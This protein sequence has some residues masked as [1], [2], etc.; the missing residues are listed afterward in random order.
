MEFKSL[1][2]FYNKVEKKIKTNILHKKDIYRPFKNDIDQNNWDARLSNNNYKDYIKERSSNG[3]LTTNCGYLDVNKFINE[4]RKYFKR[5][6]NYKK[7]EFKNSFTEDRKKVKMKN[8]N[9]SKIVMCTG[10]NEKNS[11]YFSFLPLKELSGNSI[12]IES[13][14][15]TKNPPSLEPSCF[16]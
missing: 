8:F 3:V 13:L 4:T 10:I 1:E 16:S 5:L 14:F 11:K 7:Y 9:G 15:K 12:L 6:N 2:T